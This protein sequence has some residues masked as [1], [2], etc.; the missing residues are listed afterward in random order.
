LSADVPED[1]GPSIKPAR[2][3]RRGRGNNKLFL[4]N[5]ILIVSN[6]PYTDIEQ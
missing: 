1:D 3:L 5:S 2:G 6:P 4:G